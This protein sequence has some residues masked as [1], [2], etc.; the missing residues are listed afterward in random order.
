[1]K[2]G[3]PSQLAEPG[4]LNSR[5]AASDCIFFYPDKVGI[6]RSST[7]QPP[8]L[9]SLVSPLLS[10]VPLVIRQMT[11]VQTNYRSIILR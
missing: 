3:C 7:I 9:L 10:L 1:M 8:P 6:T 2:G 11:R 5:L 4:S